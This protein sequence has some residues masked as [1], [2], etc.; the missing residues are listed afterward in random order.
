MAAAVSGQSRSIGVNAR[1]IARRSG[2]NSGSSA[3]T[4]R[5]LLRRR[6]KVR[7]AA[8]ARLQGGTAVVRFEVAPI[9][10][11]PRIA[12]DRLAGGERAVED[13][14]AGVEA[15]IQAVDRLHGAIGDVRLR[16]DLA[17]RGPQSPLRENDQ[18][19]S[20]ARN[21]HGDT[22]VPPLLSRYT[23][24]IDREGRGAAQRRCRIRGNAALTLPGA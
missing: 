17:R 11:R 4:D 13:E 16:G 21:D 22:H 8:P 23:Y 7:D 20:R 1:T 14:L 24:K 19:Q 15:F 3:S 5:V 2:R 10:Q 18:R 12:D 9:A 6:G